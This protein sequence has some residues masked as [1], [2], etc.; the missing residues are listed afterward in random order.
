MN[1]SPYVADFNTMVSCDLQE[2]VL[3][4]EPAAVVFVAMWPQH[5]PG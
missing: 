4:E 3:A 2:S 1:T 5:V